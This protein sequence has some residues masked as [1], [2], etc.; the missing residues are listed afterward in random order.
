MSP[1]PDLPAA[2]RTLLARRSVAP[3]RLA[4]PGPSPGELE[5]VV[6]AALRGPDHGDLAPWRVIHIE[7]A[8][9]G[10]LAELFAQEKQRRDPL[11]SPADLARAREHA[12]RAPTLLA[13][14][15]SPR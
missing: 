10:E 8:R 5:Q 11:V 7:P 13:F 4:P 6:R 2:L 9:R 15:V 3:R 12:T 1:D 14:V